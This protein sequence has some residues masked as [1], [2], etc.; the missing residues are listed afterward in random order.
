MP[1]AKVEAT[2]DD[3]G[4]QAICTDFRNGRS[5]AAEFGSLIKT[6]LSWDQA[7]ALTGVSVAAYCPVKFRDPL[8]E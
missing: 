2:P 8:D 5:A 4:R 7:E 6:N 1:T 3:K